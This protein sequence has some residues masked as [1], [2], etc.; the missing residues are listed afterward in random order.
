[1]STID[2]ENIKV[3][4]IPFHKIKTLEI[5]HELNQHGEVNITGLLPTKDADD[6]MERTDETSLIIIKANAKDQPEELFV[7]TVSEIGLKR[8][9]DFREMTITLKTVSNKID[10]QRKNCS[11]QQTTMMYSTLFKQVLQGKGLVTLLVPDKP[12]GELI[13]QYNETDFEFIVRLA[14]QLGSVVISNILSREVHLYIGIPTTGEI[15]NIETSGYGI[16]RSENAYQSNTSNSNSDKIV[17]REDFSKESVRSFDYAFLGDIILINGNQ[18]RVSSVVARLYD[19]ILECSYELGFEASFIPKQVINKQATGRMLTGNVTAVKEDKVQ[20]FLTSVDG[21]ADGSSDWWF[22]YSTAYSS[23][24]GSG[25]YAMPEVGD[26]VRVFFP[27]DNE[28]DAFAASSV[29]KNIRPNVKEKCFSGVNGKQILLTEDGITIIC[30][31]GK[32]HINMNTA[33]GI[34]IL[35]DMNINITSGSKVNIQAGEEI[36][37]I[38]KNEIMIGTPGAYIDIRPEEIIMS[39]ENILLK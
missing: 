23:Q 9:N 39:A 35:S 1:M 32:M 11:F 36:K 16:H 5:K 19:G 25:W 3:E 14:S 22:P 2:Y 31:N 38:A 6:F 26:G 13:M 34:E 30:K 17:M 28:A 29:T 18:R 20:V 33:T 37:M 27:S 4:G 10:I 21:S 7:G 12:I 15:R 24:D 8:E